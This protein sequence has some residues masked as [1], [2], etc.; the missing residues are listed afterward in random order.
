[1]RKANIVS[2]VSTFLS[3]FDVKFEGNNRIASEMLP[4]IF[5]FVNA[6]SGI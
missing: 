3:A 4:L 1:M 2:I 6:I 5:I